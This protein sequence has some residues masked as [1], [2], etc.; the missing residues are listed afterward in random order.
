[1][2][3]DHQRLVLRADRPDRDGRAVAQLPRGDVLRRIRPDRERREVFVA[4]LRAVENDARVERHE[5]AAADVERVD[6]DL[7]DP[8][9][10]DDEVAEAHEQ[11]V[12]AREIDRG[13]ATHAVERG[14]DARLLHHPA[15]KRGVERR[16]SERAVFEDFDEFSARAEEQHRAEL[17][18]GGAAQNEFVAVSRDHRLDRHAQE[19]VRRIPLPDASFDLAER[20]SHGGCAM[21]VQLHAA[22]IALVRDRL[23]ENFEHDRS[24]DLR[25]EFDGR[26]FA[27]RNLRLDGGNAVG[28]EQFLGFDLR[29]QRSSGMA[30]GVNNLRGPRAMLRVLS[31]VRRERGRLV[32]RVERVAVAPHVGKGARGG[33]RVFVSRNVRA[34]QD[35]VA[36][37]DL[38]SAHPA[39]EERLPAEL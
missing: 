7:L 37:G 29:E 32:K 31:G 17:R 28:G 21:H 27:P 6:V 39:R 33:I 8:A 25:R 5:V 10:L 26:F 18:I 30:R 13:A 16:Q 4:K 19:I 1:M 3:L 22:D 20:A 15:R 14:E 23:G 34:V 36:L 24:A 38:A 9:L 11:L 12:E 2:E 35:R